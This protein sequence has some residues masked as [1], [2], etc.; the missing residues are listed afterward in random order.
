MKPL[1]IDVGRDRCLRERRG[2]DERYEGAGGES[3]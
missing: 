3:V 2:Q 1:R